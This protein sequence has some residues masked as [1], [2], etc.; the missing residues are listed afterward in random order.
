[1]AK[2]ALVFCVEC[3]E[4]GPLIGSRCGDKCGVE[5]IINRELGSNGICVRPKF[6]QAELSS[7]YTKGFL[8]LLDSAFKH[9]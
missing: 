3:F 7:F 2:C 8:E 6:A 1:M 4:H 5:I 9:C